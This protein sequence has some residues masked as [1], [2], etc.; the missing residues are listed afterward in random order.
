MTTQRPKILFICDKWVNGLKKYG[1]SEWDAGMQSSLESTGLAE[2]DVFHLDDYYIQNG[3][4]GDEALLQKI[5][6]YKPNMIYLI[7]NKLP[8]TSTKVPDWS[9]FET[10]K[11]EFKIPLIALFGDLPTTEQVKISLAILPYAKL[12]VATAIT[13]AFARINRPNKYLYMWVPRDPRIFNNPNK[14]RN[15]DVGYFGSPRKDRMPHI[16]YLIKHNIKVIHGGGE[17]NE[18]LT[19]EQYADRYQRSKIVLSFA[20][21]RVSHVI[22]ARPFE[23]MPCGAMLL[24]QESFETMKLYI[25]YVDYVPYTSKRDMLKKAKYYLAHDEEREKIALSGQKKT[26]ELYSAKRFW[27]T[28]INRA[29]EPT[30]EQKYLLDNS[31]PEGTFQYLSSLTTLRMKTLNKLCSTYPGFFVYKIYHW[32]YW[33]ELVYAISAHTKPIFQKLLPERAVT[34]IV[35]IKRLILGSY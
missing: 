22:N 12:V 25:P 33:Q 5:A 26:E 32:R 6:T 7:T 20:R 21:S 10:I 23:V 1:L 24:E 3:K 9:T 8:G 16:W 34:F 27:E 29:L 11:N 2:A 31:F 35:K 13:A 30:T 28:V 4:K 17:G 14:E 18:H 19:V 15:I